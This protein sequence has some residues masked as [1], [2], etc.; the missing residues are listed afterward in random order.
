MHDRRNFF[1]T[2]AMLGVS[3]PV[4][5]KLLSPRKTFMPMEETEALIM[6]SRGADW[7][8]K[9]LK[10]AWHTL[11]ETNNI[12]DAIEAGGNVCELDPS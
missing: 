9:V 5:D 11:K 7:A 1:Q 10:P 12:L 3:L 2:L 8:E 4:A 6:C